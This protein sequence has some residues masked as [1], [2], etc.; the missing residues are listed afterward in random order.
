MKILII[1]IIIG[2]GLTVGGFSLFTSE[3]NNLEPQ[4]T[5]KMEYDATITIGTIHRNSEKMY[6]RYQPL[7][8]YLAEELS[9]DEITYKGMAK[10]YPSEQQMV[11]SINNGEMDIFF[12]SPLI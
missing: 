9:N 4:I 1:L 3:S 6:K 8:D 10:I 5:E 11:N 7:A 2:I 12:D